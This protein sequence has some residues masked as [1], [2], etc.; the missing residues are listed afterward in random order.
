MDLSMARPLS[1]CWKRCA[2]AM[3]SNRNIRSNSCSCLVYCSSF[4]GA[5]ASSCTSFISS[6]SISLPSP[7]SEELAGQALFHE[8]L[9]HQRA[10]ALRRAVGGDMGEL[11]QD[12]I[13]LG[14]EDAKQRRSGEQTGDATGESCHG[15]LRFVVV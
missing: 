7:Y 6:A 14:A 15:E 3:S 12:R 2:A 9:E 5:G 13:G 4:D 10:L 11:D 8:L 1:D